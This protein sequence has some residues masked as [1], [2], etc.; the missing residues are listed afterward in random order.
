MQL[1]RNIFTTIYIM[2]IYVYLY[3]SR[4]YRVTDELIKMPVFL[5]MMFIDIIL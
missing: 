5:A 3:L 2:N 1:I 4:P